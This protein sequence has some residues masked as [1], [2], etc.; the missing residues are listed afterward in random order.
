[1]FP[2][3]THD[4]NSQTIA[5]VLKLISPNARNHSY[6]RSYECPQR[7]YDADQP[8]RSLIDTV[9][10]SNNFHPTGHRPFTEREFASL[11]T[12]PQGE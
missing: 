4:D 10:G 9:G 12:F 3:P 7:P 6:P 8:L 5:S 2:A 1:M 11:Q